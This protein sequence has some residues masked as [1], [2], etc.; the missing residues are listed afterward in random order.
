MAIT[1]HSAGKNWEARNG[2]AVLAIKSTSA[3]AYAFATLTERQVAAFG[4][5]AMPKAVGLAGKSK[6]AKAPRKLGVKCDASNY[7][8]IW[9]D[10]YSVTDNYDGTC[11]C[12][13]CGK[14]IKLRK[15]NGMW[16]I[17]AHNV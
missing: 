5:E 16:F 7:R 10:F 4:E 12:D 9:R 15:F 14:K 8:I 3:E 11:T 17:P 1:V 6:K 2:N 13:T